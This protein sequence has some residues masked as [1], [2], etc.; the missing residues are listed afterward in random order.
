MTREGTS[1]LEMRLA[2]LSPQPETSPS[3]HKVPRQLRDVN[4]K[5]YEPEMVPIGPYHHDKLKFKMAEELK[6]RYFESLLQR[7]PEIPV[8]DYISDIQEILKEAR[9]CYAEPSMNLDSDEEFTD[10]LVLDGCFIIEVIRI[11]DTKL[12]KRTFPDRSS[13]RNIKRDLILL[14]NQIPLFV[15]CKLFDRVEEQGQ[16][17]SLIENLLYF[18][19][20]LFPDVEW[21]QTNKVGSLKEVKHILDFVHRHWCPRPPSPIDDHHT[22]SVSIPWCCPS[23]SP[24]TYSTSVI[25]SA[26]KLKDANVKFQNKKF[27]SKTSLFDVKFESGGRLVMPI[28]VVVDDTESLLRNLI[29][30]EQ[31]FPLYKP[32]YVSDY[33]F[34]LD[35]L[36]NTS[37]DVQILSGKGIIENMLGSDEAVVEIVNRLTDEIMFNTYRFIYADLFRD[38]NVH[39]QKRWNRAVAAFHRDYFSSPWAY[40]AFLGAVLLLLLTVAQT[41]FSALQVF[42]KPPLN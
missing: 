37:K 29:A 22:R 16:H 13:Y 8:K 4:I 7:K 9:D 30:Y 36:I 31:L 35:C 1:R 25:P 18:C 34:L 42:D 28:L 17:N 10:M 39:H 19:C 3:I 12:Y 15:L 38:I 6:W 21:H 27:I 26:S 5:A 33:A 32:A 20:E 40:I 41:I 11:Q 2:Q 23:P 14:E 24:E